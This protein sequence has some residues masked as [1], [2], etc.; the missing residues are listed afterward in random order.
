MWQEH[1]VQ[2]ILNF[3][4]SLNKLGNLLSWSVEPH[5]VITRWLEQ[6][7][8]FKDPNTDSYLKQVMELEATVKEMN[9]DLTIM[10]GKMTMRWKG[11]KNLNAFMWY[12]SVEE[13]ELFM[14]LS[15]SRRVANICYQY[16]FPELVGLRGLCLGQPLPCCE[17]VLWTSPRARTRWVHLFKKICGFSLQY[18]EQYHG[19]DERWMLRMS[20]ER[21]KKHKRRI[22]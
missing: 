12:K 9:W 18:E 6:N 22:S 20:R 14:T 2:T 10:N 16:L 11:L 5:Q 1:T 19:N 17:Y 8:Q 7:N 4:P 13:D 15:G 21:Q 3:C